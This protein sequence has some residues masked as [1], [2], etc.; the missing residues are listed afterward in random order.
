MD[1]LK[2]PQQTSLNRDCVIYTAQTFMV[3]LS[4]E[5]EAVRNFPRR[6]AEI[7]NIETYLT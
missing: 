7:C 3:S 5:A 6:N 4:R 2:P 1:L